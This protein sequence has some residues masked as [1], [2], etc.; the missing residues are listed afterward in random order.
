MT[1]TNL[2]YQQ[3]EFI[4]TFLWDNGQTN[5]TLNLC[6]GTHSVVIT[7]S[8]GCTN[9][10]TVFVENPDTLKLNTI[11]IDSSCYEICDGE[12]EVTITGGTGPYDI[13]WKLN[14]NTIDSNTTSIQNL[15]PDTYDIVYVD[16]KNCLESKSITLFERDSFV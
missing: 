10:N 4:L 13:F 1:A 3:T 15:C 6:Y 7:D 12:I 9:T 5:D 2:L 11:T 16:Q 8:S 14:G